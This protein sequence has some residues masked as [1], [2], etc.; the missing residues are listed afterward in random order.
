MGARLPSKMHRAAM[1]DA[2]RCVDC[3]STLRWL[4]HRTAFSIPPQHC[5]PAILLN[6]TIWPASRIRKAHRGKGGIGFRGI[7]KCIREKPKAGFV[8]PRILFER[9]T[10]LDSHHCALRLERRGSESRCPANPICMNTGSLPRDGNQ[11]RLYHD[12]LPRF[13]IGVWIVLSTG[14][15]SQSITQTSHP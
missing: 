6:G 8:P 9:K 15:A 5:M 3:C 12:V 4:M 1:A 7:M 2:P 10:G 14:S 11:Y 13:S